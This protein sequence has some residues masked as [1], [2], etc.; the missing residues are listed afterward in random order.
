MPQSGAE[1][2]AAVAEGAKFIH[3]A[4]AGG[5]VVLALHMFQRVPLFLCKFNT[6]TDD[7]ISPELAA[8]GLPLN[9]IT[10]TFFLEPFGLGFVTILIPR[11][12]KRG[13]SIPAV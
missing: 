6:E 9:Q 13:G 2:V 5:V 4:L 12:A 3:G 10:R 7:D 1:D 8:N 11:N